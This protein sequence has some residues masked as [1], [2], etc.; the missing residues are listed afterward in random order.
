MLRK[1]STMRSNQFRPSGTNSDWECH[2]FPST[3]PYRPWWHCRGYWPDFKS[4]LDNHVWYLLRCIGM[5]SLGGKDQSAQ[6]KRRS[7]SNPPLHPPPPPPPPAKKKKEKRKE[8]GTGRLGFGPES[9]SDCDLAG[10]LREVTRNMHAPI[11]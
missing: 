7:R 2:G 4:A 9:R 6:K 10:A 11:I 3:S 5:P 8:K 1:R